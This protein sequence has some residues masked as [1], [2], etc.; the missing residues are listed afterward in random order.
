MDGEDLVGFDQ[1][2]Y[3]MIVLNFKLLEF[4]FVQTHLLSR[5]NRE[6]ACQR[7]LHALVAKVNAPQDQSLPVF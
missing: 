3:V 5:L 2:G 6:Q 7:G 4:S 1:K